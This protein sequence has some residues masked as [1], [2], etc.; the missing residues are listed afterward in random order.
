VWDF[1]IGG[2][3]V[4][5]KYLKSRKDYVLSLDEINRVGAISDGVAFTLAQ[6]VNR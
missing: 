6:M 3:R 2:Y 1:H 5:D 4:L